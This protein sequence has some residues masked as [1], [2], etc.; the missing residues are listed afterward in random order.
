MLFISDLEDFPVPPSVRIPVTVHF[1]GRLINS[2]EVR[3]Y[4]CVFVCVCV[5]S[6][7]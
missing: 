1:A 3:V 4:V 5:F 6:N 2:N 7:E